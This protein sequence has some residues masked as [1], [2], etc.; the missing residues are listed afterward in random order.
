MNKK[1]YI[2]PEVEVVNVMAESQMMAASTYSNDDTVAAGEELAGGRRG[3][4]GNLW[5]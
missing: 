2:T 5:E 1:A 4:W 3:T